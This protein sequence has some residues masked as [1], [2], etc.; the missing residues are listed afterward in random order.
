M[1]RRIKKTKIPL[2]VFI[3]ASLSV[4]SSAP[5][6]GQTVRSR[7]V[8]VNNVQS[9]LSEEGTLGRE[10]ASGGQLGIYYPALGSQLFAY[11]EYIV[12]TS[13]AGDTLR[14]AEGGWQTQFRPGV[15]TSLFGPD[16]STNPRYH[17]YKLQ[18][19][20]QS[21]SGG[22]ELTQLRDDFEAWPVDLGAPADAHGVPVHLG[23]QTLWTVSNDKDTL[24]RPG[25]RRITPP[26]N[27]E[28]QTSVW[29]FRDSPILSSVLLVRYNLINKG[30]VQW[31]DAYVGLHLDLN[32]DNA[33]SYVGCDTT[34][35][36]GFGYYPGPTSRKYP[37]VPPAFGL[38]L[39][40]GPTV[41]APG[42]VGLKNG[43]EVRDV[44]NLGMTS[45]YRYLYRAN[46]PLDD[47]ASNPLGVHNQLKGLY[48]NGQPIFNRITGE[49]TT[50]FVPGDPIKNSGWTE[51]AEAVGPSYR[52]MRLG[53]G[54]FVCSPGDTQS[55]VFALIAGKGVDHLQSI[56]VVRYLARYVRTRYLNNNQ[57]MTWAM[58]EVSRASLSNRV[59][60]SWN[61]SAEYS[62]KGYDFQGY[63]VYQGESA[64][65]PWHRIATFDK[66]DGLFYL[67]DEELDVSTGLIDQKVKFTLPNKGVQRYI[68]ITTDSLRQKSLANGTSYWFAVTSFAYNSDARPMVAES[69]IVPIEC[70]PQD[71]LFSENLETYGQL[72][73][74]SRP[75]DDI[76]KLKVIDPYRLKDKNYRLEF[77]ISAGD[78]LW[79]LIDVTESDTLYARQPIQSNPDSYPI[80]DGFIPIIQTNLH[81]L[82][83]DFQ[84]PRGW[85]YVPKQNRFFDGAA[86]KK[87]MDGL[88]N[89][90]AY[91]RDLNYTGY[92]SGLSPD[93]L[94]KVEIRFD[95]AKTQK[96]YRYVALYRSFPPDPPRHPS[97]IPYLIRRGVGYVYQ[98]QRD[99][100]F[101]VWEIDSSDGDPAPRQ[102][103]V[104]FVERND[105]LVN[106]RGTF[107]GGG[108]VNGEWEPL[109]SATGGGELLYIFASD[110]SETPDSLYANTDL[111]FK[112]QR[113]DIMYALELRADPNLRS[114]GKT[115][116]D[117]GDRF[118]L[119]PNYPI[120]DGRRFE[121]T[122]TAPRMADLSSKKELVLSRIT[123]FP[124]PYLGGHS[125][126]TSITQRYVTFGNIPG[127]S[128]IDIYSLT[129]LLVKSID[130]DQTATPFV[131]W[132]LKNDHGLYVA[133]GIYIAR[134]SVPGVGAVTRKVALLVPEVRARS[135]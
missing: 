132:D 79:T 30:P 64:Q 134:V 123:V 126:E 48:D 33:G 20:W 59:I 35:N 28:L 1:V 73:P 40:E 65:G 54:P 21:V 84:V 100:P 22:T 113:F 130:A 41:P 81:G 32:M 99:V 91:P 9:Y 38:A 111:L 80:V 121:F 34:L 97:Y 74:H 6:L 60:L 43:A 125:N 36:I 118:I 109:A 12:L 90:I 94:R 88:N 52:E 39:L 77:T 10:R 37:G 50:F 17:T 67:L 75:N 53:S 78:T 93:K 25:W 127:G 61:E 5:I 7:T 85:E 124:N 117:D 95:R 120:V 116:F 135:Y 47:I 4:S 86:P 83:R 115:T 76:L 98:D 104:A 19:D 15:H 8:N 57:P 114:D 44:R 92:G 42:M 63:H 129:G 18:R 72:L 46:Y 131:R 16:S 107:V 45:F 108:M 133:S 51:S 27:A 26:L 3:V 87:I 31:R 11:M 102:L 119:Q 69:P 96:A 2:F 66:V 55:V 29:G 13:Y 68:E 112:S 62:K 105:S 24:I 106:Y 23:D 103:N 70:V 122:T 82:R 128:R 58:P 56:N 101:T 71:P 49:R 110:Y 14:W 89:G